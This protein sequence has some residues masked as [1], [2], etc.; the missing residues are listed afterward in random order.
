MYAYMKGIKVVKYFN[1]NIK[2][3]FPYTHLILMKFI[4]EVNF[5]KQI[6]FSEEKFLL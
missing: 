2:F 4:S 3:Y 5:H 1:F 6:I